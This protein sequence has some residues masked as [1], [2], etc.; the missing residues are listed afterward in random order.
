MKVK[1]KFPSNPKYDGKIG[2][3][4]H[5]ITHLYTKIMY[6]VFVDGE[7]ISFYGGELE[8]C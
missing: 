2:Y 1:I 4:K 8:P 5:P 6:E 3:T 7:L